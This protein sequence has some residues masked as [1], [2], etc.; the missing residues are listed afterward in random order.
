MLQDSFEKTLQRRQRLAQIIEQSIKES[1][2]EAS[3]LLTAVAKAY[4]SGSFT[5]FWDFL[6]ALSGS[7]R[8]YGNDWFFTACELLKQKTGEEIKE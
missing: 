4:Y 8:G 3:D 7:D 5:R 6:A 1:P 2:A